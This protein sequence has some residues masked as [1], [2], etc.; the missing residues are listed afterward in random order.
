M[1]LILGV[2]VVNVGRNE[3]RVLGIFEEQINDVP[4]RLAFAD[5]KEDGTVLGWKHRR[6]RDDKVLDVFAAGER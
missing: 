4:R 5:G 2:A 1:C 3:L 6:T